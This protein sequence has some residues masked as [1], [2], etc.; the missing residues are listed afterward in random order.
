M[1][2]P[3]QLRRQLEQVD[4]MLN[5]APAPDGTPSPSTPVDTATPAETTPAQPETTPAQLPAASAPVRVVPDDWEAKYRTLQGK[6]DA[7]VPRLHQTVRELNAQMGSMQQLVANL[8]ATPAPNQ[9][10]QPTAPPQKLVSDKEVQEYGADT[11]DLVRRVVREEVGPLLG[12]LRGQL[13]QFGSRVSSQVQQVATRQNMTADETF[14]ARLDQALPEWKQ[15]NG[16]QQF[17]AWLS[18]VDPMT[19]IT[20][21]TY[22]DDARRNLDVARVTSIFNQF[23]AVTA[24]TVPATRS[25]PATELEKQIAPG[26]SRSDAAPVTPSPQKRTYTTTEISQ[27]YD[28]VLR[29]KYKNRAQEKDQIERDIFLAQRENRIKRV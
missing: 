26:K 15:I 19:G 10:S 18:E 24:Q 14:F 13:N 6:Y 5:P 2:L 27:F 20:R 16:N 4:Q 25:N 17:H 21:Q 29:G 23:K 28:D 7:E 22:L 12:E 3:E 1:A 11:I 9:P 8:N